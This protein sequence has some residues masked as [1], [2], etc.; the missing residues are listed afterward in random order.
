MRFCS[1]SVLAVSVVIIFLTGCDVFS[2]YH[3]V[4]VRSR[5]SYEWAIDVDGSFSGG[6][7]PNDEGYILNVREGTHVLTFTNLTLSERGS[8][9][10]YTRT[11]DID[12]NSVIVIE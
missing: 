9:V 2:R 3:D 1:V 7:M 11:M 12:E 10:E 6:V 8:L 5:T 4:P